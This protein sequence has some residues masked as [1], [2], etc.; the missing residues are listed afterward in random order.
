[1]SAAALFTVRAQEAEET[2]ATGFEAYRLIVSRNIFDPTRRPDR[3]SQSV[4]RVEPP[5]T[6]RLEF[7][8]TLIDINEPEDSQA[9]FKSTEPRLQRALKKDEEIAGYTLVAIEPTK[10]RLQLGDEEVFDFEKGQ[11]MVRNEN[12]DW[13][14]TS[15]PQPFG[16]A[17]SSSERRGNRNTARGSLNNRREGNSENNVNLFSGNN[18]GRANRNNRDGGRGGNNGGFGNFNQEETRSAAPVV[19]AE[20][21]ETSGASQAEILRLMRERREREMER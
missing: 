17:A 15:N 10:V 20:P 9:F 2:E 1:L 8:G 14:I 11:Q 16:S 18:G 19:T 4:E 21:I 7:V 3:P 6:D 5:R 13:E 12:E